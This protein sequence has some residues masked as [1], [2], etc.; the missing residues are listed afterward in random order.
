M[1]I[2]GRAIE[3]Y[4]ND[5]LG[6]KKIF[7]VILVQ[8][9]KEYLLATSSPLTGF[10]TPPDMDLKCVK[11]DVRGGSAKKFVFVGDSYNALEAT[12]LKRKTIGNYF[13]DIQLFDKRPADFK[14]YMYSFLFGNG[15]SVDDKFRELRDYIQSFKNDPDIKTN[16]EAGRLSSIFSNENSEVVVNGISMKTGDDLDSVNYFADAI[17]KVPY[18]LCSDNFI[19]LSAKTF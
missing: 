11:D 14:N 5:D 4:F 18:K 15:G 19:L 12:P 8:D 9:G 1:P 13:H 7:F 2:L 17:L 10:I 16:W 6:E 3:S